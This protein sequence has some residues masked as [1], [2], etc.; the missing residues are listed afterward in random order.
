MAAVRAT[1]GPSASAHPFVFLHHHCS[2]NHTALDAAD[3]AIYRGAQLGIRFIVPL[4][5]NWK[6]YHGGK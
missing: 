6:Y 5:D 3:Y 4:T 1:Y 2:F